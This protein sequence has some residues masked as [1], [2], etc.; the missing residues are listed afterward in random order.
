MLRVSEV[1]RIDGIAPG[2]DLGADPTAFGS[3]DGAVVVGFAEGLQ[4]GRIEKESPVALVRDAMVD[5][6]GRLDAGAVFHLTKGLPLQLG[7]LELSPF[8]RRV[9]VAPGRSG[10]APPIGGAHDSVVGDIE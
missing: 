9:E 7:L 1:E 5:D 2:V 10:G 3:L 4:V 8:P 6:G